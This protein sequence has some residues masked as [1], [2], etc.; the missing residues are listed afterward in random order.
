[1]A[2]RGSLAKAPEP[3]AFHGRVRKWEKQW[4]K[5]SVKEASLSRWVPT[6]LFIPF[7]LSSNQL[8]A[9]GMPVR[10]AD[11]GFLLA[12]EKTVDQPVPRKPHLVPV[13]SCFIEPA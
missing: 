11:G 7:S 6:G 2:T 1:M 9:A 5:G 13:K 10:Q 8:E 3:Q 12:D 4:T